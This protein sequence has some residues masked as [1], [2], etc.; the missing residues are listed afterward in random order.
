MIVFLESSFKIEKG[1]KY[2]SQDT[3]L[4]IIVPC[5]VSISVP[6]H[7][8]C[9]FYHPILVKYSSPLLPTPQLPSYLYTGTR[10]YLL[11]LT[12]PRSHQ[13]PAPFISK[14]VVAFLRRLYQCR[15]VEVDPIDFL[16]D[17]GSL[18]PDLVI[19]FVVKEGL[20]SRDLSCFQAP[21]VRWRHP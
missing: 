6:S 10:C 8:C 13:L 3:P 2:P 15:V 16:K 12:P 18:F 21:L 5:W 20:K 9:R 1:S 4:D 19:H 17:A 14:T 11:D 7:S